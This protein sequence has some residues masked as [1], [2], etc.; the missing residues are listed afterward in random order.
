[1][2]RSILKDIEKWDVEGPEKAIRLSTSERM[3]HGVLEE[4]PLYS[5]HEMLMDLVT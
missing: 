2:E 5:I 3:S 1:M 4:Y